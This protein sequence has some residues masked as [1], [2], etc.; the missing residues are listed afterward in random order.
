ARQ[1]WPNLPLV[2]LINEGSASASEIVAGALQDHD[3]ALVVGRTSYG[4]GSAQNVYPTPGGGALKLTTA[5]WYT[6]V[7]R[8]ITKLTKSDDDAPD[9]TDGDRPRAKPERKTFKTDAGRTVY[10]GGG[11]TPDVLSG[12]TATT[13]MELA[14]Q[15]ALGRRIPQFRDAMTEYAISLRASH[16][17]AT[18]EFTVSPEM[19]DQL[20]RRL[21]AKN[22]TF[23][24]SIYEQAAPLVSRL[25][26]Y[27][28]TRYV[29]GPVAEA[30]RIARD[31]VTIR[32]SVDMLR[33]VTT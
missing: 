9:G 8:T 16:A 7:G 12:D 5:R 2:V 1:R 25:L 11:I 20:W 33:G 6:P 31:D 22:I 24:R 21:A 27:E 19:R 13:P 4:K 30:R 28:I 10:G 26:G 15:T 17:V 3:R 14:L 29:F 32:L 18:P 23:D